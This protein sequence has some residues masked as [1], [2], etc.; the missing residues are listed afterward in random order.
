MRQAGVAVTVSEYDDMIHGFLLF[1][2]FLD[3][4]RTAL[5]DAGRALGAALS[6]AR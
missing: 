5:R 6:V 2:R 1:T 3:G 4:G